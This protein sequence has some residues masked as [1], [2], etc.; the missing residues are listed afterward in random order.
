MRFIAPQNY[1]RSPKGEAEL[2]FVGTKRVKIARGVYLIV[3]LLL[4][5]VPVGAIVVQLFLED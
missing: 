1:F 4:L 5:A 3:A 2:A